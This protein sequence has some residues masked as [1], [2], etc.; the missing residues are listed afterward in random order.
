[1]KKNTY[2]CCFTGYRPS[3]LPFCKNKNSNEYM[4]FENQVIELLASLIYEGCT[5][6]YC[7]MAMGFDIICAEIVLLL[8]KAYKNVDIKLICVVPFKGQENTFTPEWQDRYSKILKSADKVVTLCP[9]YH[10]G[11]YQQRNIYMVDN[12]DFIV[13]WFDGKAGGTSNTL[14]YALSKNRKIFNLNSDFEDNYFTQQKM[15]I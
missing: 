10:K 3:K 13:T 8:K 2:K 15:D 6:F 7:G 11:S 12:S 5:T 1:M 4:V 14:K 9:V